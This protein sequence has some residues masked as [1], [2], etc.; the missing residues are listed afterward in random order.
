MNWTFIICTHDP[1]QERVD[2]SIQT[3]EDL[4]IP[5]YEVIVIGGQRSNKSWPNENVKFIDFNEKTRPGWTTKKKNEAAKLAKYENLCIFHDYFAFD[6][7]WYE[8]WLEF[9]KQGHRWNVAC[10]QIKL[11]NGAREWTDWITW[12]DPVYK[13]GKCFPYDDWSRTRFQYV[14]G[15]YFCIKKDFFLSNPFSE[16]LGSHEHEDIEWSLRIRDKWKLV[17]N[18]LSIVRHTKWHRDMRKWRKHAKSMI[19]NDQKKNLK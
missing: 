16:E 13:K 10:N 11:I 2:I 3:I 9:E 14:S 5:N 1:N 17:C 6:F 8:G 19:K 4:A 15:G 18:S 7:Y 12:D